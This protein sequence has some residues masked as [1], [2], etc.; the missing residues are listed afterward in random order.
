MEQGHFVLEGSN[1]ETTMQ[2]PRSVRKEA[3]Q[4][5]GVVISLWK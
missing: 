1:T 2:T 5:S 3:G 4:Y